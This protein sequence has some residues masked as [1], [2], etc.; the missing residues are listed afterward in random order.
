MRMD[1]VSC[2]SY[3]KL[4]VL[5]QPRVIF[6]LCFGGKIVILL[7]KKRKRNSIKRMCPS[8]IRG[9]LGPIQLYH[10]TLGGTIG[11][12]WLLGFCIIC[13]GWRF[14]SSGAMGGMNN[15]PG[16]VYP[17]FTPSGL[18]AAVNCGVMGMLTCNWERGDHRFYSQE[19]EERVRA[20]N[21]CTTGG[22]FKHLVMCWNNYGFFCLCGCAQ[23]RHD[24]KTQG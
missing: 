13:C 15:P 19:W 23:K 18:T 24:S 17:C 12:A 4:L 5:Q 2:H 6:C 7:E 3:R 21:S 20:C 22:S 11:I 14:C 9:R 1:Q 16:E 8:L 10:H